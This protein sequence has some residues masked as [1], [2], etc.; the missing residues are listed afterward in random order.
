MGQGGGMIHLIEINR[1]REVFTLGEAQRLL[2]IIMRMTEEY[3]RQFNHTLAELERLEENNHEKRNELESQAKEL[4][5]LWSDKVSKLGA[6]PNGLWVVDFD[7]GDGYYCWKY[8]E[9]KVDYWHPY[10]AGFS[11]RRQIRIL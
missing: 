3:T 1:K 4:V 9:A 8:P 5:A 10:D 2:P 7:S 6:Y 11:G